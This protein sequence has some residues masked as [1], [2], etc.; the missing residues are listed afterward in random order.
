MGDTPELLD[1]DGRVIAKVGRIQAF[2][3][4]RD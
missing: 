1:S 2:S 3:Y 4:P